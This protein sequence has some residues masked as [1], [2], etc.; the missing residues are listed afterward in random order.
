M[1]VVSSSNAGASRAEAAIWADGNVYDTILTP[2]TFKEPNNH[3]SLDL[4]YV[5][6]N[7]DGQRPIAEAAPYEKDYNGGRWNVQAV[8]FT[9]QGLS[10]IDPDNNGIA[11][12]ELTSDVQLLHYMMLGYLTVMPTDIYFECPLLP[13]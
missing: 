9:D 1:L 8:Y 5:T 7:L 12:F 10:A 2:A 3:R 13:A 4:I 6:M 11:N